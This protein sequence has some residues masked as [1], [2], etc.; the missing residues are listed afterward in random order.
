VDSANFENEAHFISFAAT[1]L[2]GMGPIISIIF[3]E[4]QGGY[5]GVTYVGLVFVLQI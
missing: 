5:L 3:I 1:L 4:K 2:P